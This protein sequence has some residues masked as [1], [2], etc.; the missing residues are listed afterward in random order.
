MR[1]PEAAFIRARAKAPLPGLLVLHLS[2]SDIEC[3]KHLGLCKNLQ[4]L[5]VGSNQ[6]KDIEG[7]IELRKLWR[8]DLSGNLLKN[9]HALASFRALGF[10]HL[11]RNRICFEDL[12]CIRDVHLLEVRLLGNATLFKGNTVDDYRKKVVALLPNMWI[13]DGHFVS[14]AERRQAVEEFDEFF[15]SLLKLSKRAV[16]DGSKFGS[17]SD[18]WVESEAITDDSVELNCTASL[19]D[20]ALKVSPPE[21]LSDLRRLE[22][23]VSFH[24]AES[25][26]HNSHSH[27]APSKF[28]SNAR[29]MPKIWMDEILALPR[30]TRLEVVILIATFL[31]FRYPTVLLSEALTIRQLDSPHFPSEAIRDTVNLPAYAMVALIA[32]ARQ[33]SI[34]E[35]Q[36]MREN[37]RPDA[38]SRQFQDESEMLAAI[39]PLFETLLGLKGTTTHSADASALQATTMRCR[40]AVKLL[41]NVASFPDP[42]I[43]AF[44]G[45]S[46]REAIVRQIMP[47]IRAAESAPTSPA[48]LSGHEVVVPSPIKS[49]VLDHN[50]KMVWKRNMAVQNTEKSSEPAVLP[51]GDAEVRQYDVS[52]DRSGET[53]SATRR[54]PK[55]GDWVEVCLRQFVKIQFLSADG[56]FVVG[57]LPTDA[58]RTIAISVEQMSRISNTVWRVK[59]LTKQQSGE[60]FTGTQ[61]SRTDGAAPN[62]TRIGKLHRDSEAFHRHGATLNQGFPNHFVTSQM[63]ENLDRGR[64]NTT[65]SSSQKKA[66]EI[67]SS[68]DTL[69]ANYVLTSPE[70]ISAQNYCAVSS[71][72]QQRRAPMGLW[73]PVKQPAPYS[74]LGREALA[75]SSSLNELKARKPRVVYAAAP[76]QPDDWLEIRREMKAQ[77]GIVD[78]ADPCVDASDRPTT[79]CSSRSSD[80]N[81]MIH[82]DVSS[83][84]TATSDSDGIAAVQSMDREVNNYRD[85]SRLKTPPHKLVIGGGA[86]LAAARGWHQV[87]TKTEFV[88]AAP[89]NVS[90]SAPLLRPSA[91]TTKLELAVLP[92]LLPS[93]CPQAAAKR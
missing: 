8:I 88:V 32:I 75:K 9:L 14:T 68:N 5:Y 35:E 51:G 41:A 25:V 60:L 70:H 63:L 7:I 33:F 38:A 29:I 47:L 80:S 10:L 15:T 45:K 46:K 16:A 39:P 53:S 4:S 42:G 54:K 76:Q 69:D 78:P 67:F 57:A 79:G 93:L 82:T 52:L 58:S 37:L 74:V 87:A 30:R 85:R 44:K 31:E 1:S 21:E 24:N 40:R 84:L 66:I 86:K 61:H 28:A 59:Y 89:L 34:E 3:I 56:L 83:F 43:V 22:A 71:F 90:H 55:P 50:S 91:S 72:Q 27:F 62:N 64:V 19:I 81:L 26:I 36:A 18:V 48:T 17:A 11:E 23:V 6:I 73:S 12:V 77:L 13:L 92:S 20:I 65:Q 2:D 49:P